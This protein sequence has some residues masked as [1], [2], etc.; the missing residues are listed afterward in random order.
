[1]S[2]LKVKTCHP[3]SKPQNTGLSV[4]IIIKVIYF[5]DKKEVYARGKMLAGF[6][7]KVE[8]RFITERLPA[9]ALEVKK[10]CEKE[11]LDTT[12]H[13]CEVKVFLKD[14]K[15]MVYSQKVGS[16]LAVEQLK[17]KAIKRSPRTNDNVSMR[18]KDNNKSNLDDVENAEYT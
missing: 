8:N 17:D 6:Q 4:P 5:R 7:F 1:M 10:E 2:C 9:A 18:R 16:T 13:N 15:G 11:N 3:L 14:H 12:T